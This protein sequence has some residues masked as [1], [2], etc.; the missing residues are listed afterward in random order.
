MIISLQ[1]A[2]YKLAHVIRNLLYDLKTS[3]LKAVGAPEVIL[4]IRENHNRQF[5]VQLRQ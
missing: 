3:S 2:K 5:M 4:G 1:V